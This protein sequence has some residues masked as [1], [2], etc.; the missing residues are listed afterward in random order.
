MSGDKYTDLTIR[1][2]M[3]NPKW[4][5]ICLIPCFGFQVTW[6][7]SSMLA[8]LYSDLT[9]GLGMKTFR[10]RLN[11]IPQLIQWCIYIN[12]SLFSNPK[13]NTE[14]QRALNFSIRY[15]FKIVTLFFFTS[16]YWKLQFSSVLWNLYG[17]ERSHYKNVGPLTDRMILHVVI[18]T[19][20]FC[21]NSL[22]NEY[23]WPF[24]I[25]HTWVTTPNSLIKISVVNAYFQ[26]FV[27]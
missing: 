8:D 13:E 1:L 11:S 24:F 22:A 10:K 20:K 17:F 9:I 6:R 2:G 26:F 23:K 21:A 16:C 18:V 14:F 19:T 5:L 4:P 3:K 15:F 25:G 27:Q 7:L 12:V